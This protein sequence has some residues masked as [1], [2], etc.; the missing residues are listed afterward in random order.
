MFVVGQAVVDSAVRRKI[1]T[2][3]TNTREYDST[4]SDQVEA[5]SQQD[6]AHDV[7]SNTKPWVNNAAL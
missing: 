6:S 1:Q 7:N 4:S 3:T 5:E 2:L